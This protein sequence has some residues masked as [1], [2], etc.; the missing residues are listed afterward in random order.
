M[1]CN[2][3]MPI[4]PSL[5]R[6]LTRRAT[7]VAAVF[8]VA[9]VA[10]AA[11]NAPESAGDAGV[12]GSAPGGEADDSSSG[13]D[14]TS[15]TSP[16]A[17]DAEPG[18]VPPAGTGAAAPLDGTTAAAGLSPAAPL[19]GGVRWIGRVD[20]SDPRAVHFA[21]SGTGFAAV[22][23]GSTISVRLQQDASP[24]FF[25]PVID[26]QV[27]PRVQVTPGPVQ[28]V[29]LGSA[30][31][32]GDH[33]V[34]LY[35]ETEGMYGDSIFSGF[36]SGTLKAPPQPSGRLI[37]VVGD[38]IS[39]GYGNLGNE[40]HPPWDNSC[41]FSIDTESAYQSYGAK[42][43]R[44]LNAE[45]SIIARSGWGL[46]EDR[47][48]N[49]S[50]VLPT[51]YANTLGMKASPVW[52]FGR[53]ADVVLINLGTNDSANGDPGPGFETAYVSFLGTVRSHYPGAW[54]FLTVGP[55]TTDPVLGQLR[56][57]LAN[58]VKTVGDPKITTVDIDTQNTTSTGCDYH[59]NVAEDD[60]MA[61]VLTPV[62]RGKL[63]W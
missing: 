5:L 14:S 39:A 8:V 36:A 46:Y 12:S 11:G 20:D 63:G 21:W 29:V 54:I 2:H 34:E 50:N 43:A 16:S 52:S 9:P 13:A 28:T 53:K 22:V 38:S 49:T 47:I 19:A 32:A 10:C 55:M 33:N 17:G 37:E 18:L 48:Q 42:I 57:R 30:L 44:S 61:E 59:P 58:V 6:E 3:R 56:T 41:T 23:S 27:M 35:R 4:H 62:I 60:T 1:Q 25:Q 7:L 26:G 24:A 31:G 45:A 15:G 40:V 51:V